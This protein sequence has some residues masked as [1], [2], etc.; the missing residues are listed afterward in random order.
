MAEEI[1]FAGDEA[2][3]RLSRM[4]ERG[5]LRRLGPGVYTTDLDDP[6]EEV[7]RRNWLPITANFCPGAIIADRSARSGE[8]GPDGDLFVVARQA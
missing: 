7:C 3:S 2:S 4:T 1:V 8:P 6:A 5:T